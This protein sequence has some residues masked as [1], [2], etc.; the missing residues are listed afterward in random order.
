MNKRQFQLLDEKEYGVYLV[1]TRLSTGLELWSL[2][3]HPGSHREEVS[4]EAGD[5]APDDNI[6][7]N[8]NRVIRYSDVVRLGRN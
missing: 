7:A 4:N 5:V 2:R 1:Y 6:V 8:D 3:G